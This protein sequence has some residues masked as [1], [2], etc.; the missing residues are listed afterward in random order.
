MKPWRFTDRTLITVFLVLALAFPASSRVAGQARAPELIAQVNH[1]ARIN[2]IVFSPDGRLIATAGSDH[3][4]KVWDAARGMLIRNLEGHAGEVRSVA[5]SRD[6]Q[7]IVSAAHDATVRVWEVATGRT[8]RSFAA[9]PRSWMVGAAFGDDENT[10]V[11]A[12][13]VSEAASFERSAERLTEI[14]VWN[15]QTGQKVRSART[16]GYCDPLVLTNDRALG[17]C[18]NG[19]LWDLAGMKRVSDDQTAYQMSHTHDATFSPN[20][21]LLALVSGYGLDVWD[22][23]RLVQV[24]KIRDLYVGGLDLMHL[25]SVTFAPDGRTIA[26]GDDKGRIALRDAATGRSLGDVVQTTE[27]KEIT[28]LAFTPDGKTLL[29]ASLGEPLPGITMWAI[30]NDS[31][32]STGPFTF[33]DRQGVNPAANGGGPSRNVNTG[34]PNSAPYGISA[35]RFSPDGRS[36][37][38]GGADSVIRLWNL[39]N[40]Q[41]ARTLRGHPHFIRN[42]AF[43]SDGNTL[44][45]TSEG[46]GYGE[47]L[48][49]WD[50]RSGAPTRVFA[51]ARLVDAVAF[52]PDGRTIVAGMQLWDASADAPIKRI[53]LVY[54]FLGM[55]PDGKTLACAW[56]RDRLHSDK[57]EIVLVDESS[58][59]ELPTRLTGHNSRITSAAFSPDNV[60][61]VTG[62]EDRTIRIWDVRTGGLT[63]TLS[64]HTGPVLSVALNPTGTLIASGSA[65]GTVKLWDASG[66]LVKT[67]TGHT[68]AVRS[69]AF[70][71]EGTTLASGSEDGTIRIWSPATGTLLASLM[72]FADGE[73]LAYG[74]QGHF[75]GS[76]DRARYVAWRVGNTVYSFEQFF[77]RFYTPDLLVRVFQG[78]ALP[79][80]EVPLGSARPPDVVIVSPRPGQTL[81]D[82]DVEVS[83]EVKDTGGGIGDVRLSLNGKQV[84]PNAATRGLTPSAPGSS[85]LRYRVSLLDGANVLRATAFSSDRT[86][87]APHEMTVRLEGPVKEAALRLLAVGISRYQ[88]PGLTLR[89]PV[90]DVKDLVTFFKTSG[91]RLFREVDIT[92]LSDEEATETNII[93]A[94]VALQRRAMPQDVVIVFLSGHGASSGSSWYFIPHDLRNPERQEELTM[95]GLSSDRL[96]QELRRVSSQKVLLLVDSCY[97]GSMLSAFRGYEDRKALALLA[98]SAGIHILAVATRDQRASEVSELGHGVFSYALLRGLGGGAA[99]RDVDKQVT[100]MSLV[101]YIRD[102]LP[103]LGRKYQAEVQDP[104]SF[105]NGMDFPLALTR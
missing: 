80:A 40:G 100:V 39:Q 64:G 105:S 67:L 49:L 29:S 89:F 34:Q 82:P 77:E 84:D 46:N 3:T 22:V 23:K 92:E 63:A 44:A 78:A 31:L 21:N 24:H 104:V 98:R 26:T 59:K 68:N 102:Q 41:L 33:V 2:S 15:M 103:D 19:E 27:K 52:H 55:S 86:E 8:L 47:G 54:D 37:A 51:S 90:A 95:H 35:V 7:R 66:R 60:R 73:W 11:S 56:Q 28:A 96:A 17:F 62:S 43:S 65:D 94:L 48:R 76:A 32:S 10:I 99:L 58:G 88:N 9:D 93:Q 70:G 42:L 30:D 97:S 13:R 74:P 14:A 20:G 4:V 45:S 81:R 83:I 25:V 5:F 57:E 61:L 85:L 18:G 16:N 71:P 50:V 6:G 79:V 87:S 38:A 53:P 72:A 36:L 12:G 1:T 75:N 69:V 101:A 91:P